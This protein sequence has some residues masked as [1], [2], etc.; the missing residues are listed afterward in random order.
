MK[1]IIIIEG[2]RNVGKSFLIN[3]IKDHF[4]VYKVPFKSWFDNILDGDI[5]NNTSDSI[6]YFSSGADIT[7]LDLY[8]KGLLKQNI[9]LDRF[10]LSNV[11]FGL[12]SGRINKEIAYKNAKYLLDTYGHLIKIIRVIGDNIEDNRNKDSWNIYNQNVTNQLYDD[13]FK[14][15]NIQH[16]EFINNFNKQSIIDFYN[17]IYS[18]Y[19]DF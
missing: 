2:N 1:P 18:I 14:D 8:S 5:K 10:F 9:I 7:L 19:K 17:L 13:L 12:Q 3:S 15:L 6:F 4:N 16:I 11:V